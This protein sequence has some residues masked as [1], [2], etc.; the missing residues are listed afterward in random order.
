MTR[1]FTPGKIILS[2]EHAVVHGKPA[3]AMAVSKGVHASWTADNSPAIE[4]QLSDRPPIHRTREEIQQLAEQVHGR[5]EA[6]LQGDSPVSE[7]TSSPEDLLLTAIHHAAPGTGGVLQLDSH[8][9]LG[10]GMGSSAACL[11]SLF[12]AIRPDWDNTTVYEKALACEHLQHGRSSGLDVAVCLHEGLIWAEQGTYSPLETDPPAGIRLY[13]TGTPESSTGECVAHVGTRFPAGHSI[14]GEFDHTARSMRQA[15]ETQNQAA[16]RHAV[17]ANHALLCTVGVVP[18]VVQQTIA[19]I[20][21][22]GGAAKVCG[23]G[24]IRGDQ[25]GVVLVSGPVHT[26]PSEWTPIL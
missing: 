21:Q 7:I 3:L 11:I 17:K 5:H 10:A 9:P 25:A 23:A 13:L 12:R 18:Q 6:F 14:W 2:G 1:S 22:Q 15:L 8:L 26:V 20:E 16:W 4:L 19:D 24:S